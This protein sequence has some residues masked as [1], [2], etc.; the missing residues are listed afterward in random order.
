MNVQIKDIYIKE[1]K[2]MALFCP[3]CAILA[4]LCNS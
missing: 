1:T 3:K 2:K 4:R